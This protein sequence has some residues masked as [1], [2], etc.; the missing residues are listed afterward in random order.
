MKAVQEKTRKANYAKYSKTKLPWFSRLLR[1]PT[2]NNMGLFHNTPDPTLGV[3]IL[4]L[5]A[6]ALLGHIALMF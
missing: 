3:C 1:H 2:V 6:F 4:K 5:F